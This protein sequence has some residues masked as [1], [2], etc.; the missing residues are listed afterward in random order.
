[1]SA[2]PL[3]LLSWSARAYK[4]HV[5]LL[6]GYAAWLLLP[7]AAF[8]LVDLLPA[9][10]T[11]VALGFA[12]V[13][14]NLVLFLWITAFLLLA[15]KRI[16]EKQTI[17]TTTLA[18]HSLRVLAPLAW[19]AILTLLV[20]SGGFLLLIIPGILFSIW[21]W[22]AGCATVLD[23]KRGL[24]ALSHSRHLYRGRFFKTGW[25]AFLGPGIL[26]LAIFLAIVLAAATLSALWLG[27]V[28]ALLC[29]FVLPFVILYTV[30]LYETLKK[31]ES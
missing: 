3:A 26:L 13:L 1:M 18:R 27:M 25:S 24:E 19:V 29:A 12:I 14:A 31:Y 28:Q 6:A 8:V 21:L 5:R 9:S 17:D 2:R 23:G 15:A 7:Y 11:T 4:T 20:T 10:P 30:A 22:F 16:F